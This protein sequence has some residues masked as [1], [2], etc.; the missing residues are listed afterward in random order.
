[1]NICRYTRQLTTFRNNFPNVGFIFANSHNNIHNIHINYGQNLC[2]LINTRKKATDYF[3]NTKTSV[4]VNP[5]DVDLLVNMN[6]DAVAYSCYS[7]SCDRKVI[8]S[9]INHVMSKMREGTFLYIG[10]FGFPIN[11]GSPTVS[12]VFTNNRTVLRYIRKITSVFYE[13]NI[14]L[15][16]YWNLYPNELVPENSVIH[17]LITNHS[18]PD[19]LFYPL[20]NP[21][22]IIIFTRNAESL[23]EKWKKAKNTTFIDNKTSVIYNLKDAGLTLRGQKDCC[24]PFWKYI[25][26][27]YGNR[28]LKIF[29]SPLK[30]TLQTLLYSS[31]N[32]FKKNSGV[33]VIIT[34]L[35]SEMGEGWENMGMCIE[36]LKTYPVVLKLQ[37][38][39]TVSFVNFKNTNKMWWETSHKKNVHKFVKHMEQKR[40]EWGVHNECVVCI[41][42]H[43]TIRQITG[44]SLSNFGRNFCFAI[45]NNI[46]DR[47]KTFL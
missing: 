28:L 47:W 31:E 22:N 26:R 3:V 30:R 4:E 34:P 6:Y 13:K 35:I 21:R 32:I 39:F 33:R 8:C 25:Q 44:L 10:E 14:R 9:A 37:E 20:M 29:V 45:S 11:F 18:S 41:S 17:G 27:I 42:H 1:M 16:F 7:S 23:D 24:N 5:A 15:A 2:S 12:Q 19:Y 46:R 38:I 36:A 40:Y 43:D